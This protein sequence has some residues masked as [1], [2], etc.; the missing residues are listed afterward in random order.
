[1]MP[2]NV[3]LLPIMELFFFFFVMSNS[4]SN[5][6]S[7]F[8]IYSSFPVEVWENP[9]DVINKTKPV[10]SRKMYIL[11]LLLSNKRLSRFE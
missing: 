4:L 6:Q 2:S 8:Y 5:E 1:M 3:E 9:V 11:L 10:N 7:R